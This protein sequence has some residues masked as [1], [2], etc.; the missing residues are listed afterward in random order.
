MLPIVS[1]ICCDFVTLTNRYAGKNQYQE[2]SKPLVHVCVA[3][4][5]MM[6][7]DHIIRDRTAR[8]TMALV[9][10]LEII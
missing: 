2:C 10:T 3:S 1:S 7:D 9:G 6:A 4:D 5:R 8:Q